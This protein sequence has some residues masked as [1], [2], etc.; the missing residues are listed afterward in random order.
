[1]SLRQEKFEC[2]LTKSAC[3]RASMGKKMIIMK[4]YDI[5][6]DVCSSN[7][8]KISF[9]LDEVSQGNDIFYTL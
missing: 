5:K 4:K 7:A 8:G 9:I 3:E 6:M 2:L 1:M